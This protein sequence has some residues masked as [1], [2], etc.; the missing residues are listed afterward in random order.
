MQQRE[1]YRHTASRRRHFLTCHP[2]APC[3]VPNLREIIPKKQRGR[4]HVKLNDCFISILYSRFSKSSVIGALHWVAHVRY[5]LTSPA[6]FTNDSQPI[7]L[8]CLSFLRK[9]YPPAGGK[10]AIGK[11]RHPDKGAKTK[12][13]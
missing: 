11:N 1:S 13:I 3:S 12:G 4:K 5:S 10:F 7:R 2:Y 9:P 8:Y 6:N